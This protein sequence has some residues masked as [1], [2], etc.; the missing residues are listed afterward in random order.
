MGENHDQQILGCFLLL[1]AILMR[2]MSQISQSP[3]VFTR[4]K[5]NIFVF[6][7]VSIANALVLLLMTEFEVTGH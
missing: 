6:V 7:K 3:A 4:K 5:H 1:L 2:L